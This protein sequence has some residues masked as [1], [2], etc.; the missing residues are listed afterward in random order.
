MPFSIAGKPYVALAWELPTGLAFDKPETETGEWRYSP[1]AKF[2]R[3][4]RACRVPI[5]LLTN[6]VAVR[7]VYAPHGET[8]GSIT[9]NLTD[10]GEVGGRPILDAFVMLVGAF[11]FF[12]VGEE[13]AVP[14]L[15]HASRERQANVTNTLAGQVFE[16]LDLLLQGFEVAARRDGRANLRALLL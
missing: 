6:G 15:L 16:A 5:G 13:A 10:M 14:A 3:L 11:R 12:G 1:A 9:F 2:D 8:T 4:L 7:L